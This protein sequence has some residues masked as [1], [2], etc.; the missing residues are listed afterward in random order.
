MYKQ[1][2]Q[3]GKTNW[4]SVKIWQQNAGCCGCSDGASRFSV[5]QKPGAHVRVVGVY[6]QSD[7]WSED[8][9]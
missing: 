1:T 7:K 4:A 2:G 6:K 5:A 3:A 9:W 8:N